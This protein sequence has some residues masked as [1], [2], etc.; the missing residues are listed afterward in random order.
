MSVWPY[1]RSTTCGITH[2]HM[3]R[4]KMT[5]NHIS[6]IKQIIALQRQTHA[7]I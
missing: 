1:V 4:G 6:C 3:R 2:T 7:R 5:R